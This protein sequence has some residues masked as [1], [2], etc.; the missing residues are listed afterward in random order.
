MIH[1]IFHTV[2]AIPEN[3]WDQVLKGTNL[4]L[5]FPYLRVLEETLQDQVTLFFSIT[6]RDKTPVL[7]TVFQL[8][9]FIDKREQWHK[10]ILKILAD[11]KS[12]KQPFKMNMLVCGNVFAQGEHGFVAAD[13]ISNEVLVKELVAISAIIKRKS[14]SCKKISVRMFKEFWPSSVTKMDALINHRFKDFYIDVN[15]VLDIHPIWT[16]FDDYLKSMKAKFRTK[17]NS[18]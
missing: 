7:I 14:V 15:M 8:V 18:T 5:S 4:Y 13:T 17:A 10:P 12:K 9:T 11:T 2:S 3:D 16:T 1:Q 6:Y